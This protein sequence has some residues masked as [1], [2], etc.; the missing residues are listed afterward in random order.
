VADYA[1][2]AEHFTYC[3]VRRAGCVVQVTVGSDR[4]LEEPGDMLDVGWGNG[5]V[6]LLLCCRRVLCRG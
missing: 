3:L 5:V 2:L 4:L 1:R 6:R